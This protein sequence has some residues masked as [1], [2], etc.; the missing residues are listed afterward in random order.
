MRNWELSLAK[1]TIPIKAMGMTS[2]Q[3][4]ENTS[5]SVLLDPRVTGNE[6]RDIKRV[7]VMAPAWH[8]R[9]R[10]WM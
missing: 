4:L 1:A 8:A 3:M 6:A 9:L 2:T 5:C 10:A 7:Q